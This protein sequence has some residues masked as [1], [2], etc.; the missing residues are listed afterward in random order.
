MN[1]RTNLTL[2]ETRVANG[3]EWSNGKPGILFAFIKQ[4]RGRYASARQQ[5][6]VAPGD[7][8]VANAS[9]AGR[10]SAISRE[11]MTMRYF[12]ASLGPLVGLFAS[13]EV[14]QLEHLN[15]RLSSLL[16]H[17]GTTPLAREC[18]ALIDTVPVRVSLA[19]RGHLLKVVTLLFSSFFEADASENR[20]GDA[21]H[22]R[23]LDLLERMD[24]ADLQNLSVSDLA[25]RL[26]CGRR[27]LNRLFHDHFGTSVAALK[28]EMRLLKAAALLRDPA[29]KVINVAM[30]SGFNHLGL[31]S[32]CFKR[33]FGASPSEWRRQNLVGHS[34]PHD[35]DD[36][37]AAPKGL[38]YEDCHF[39]YRGLCPWEKG[40]PKMVRPASGAQDGTW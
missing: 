37:S 4:G 11:G 39:R 30:D 5:Q 25:C 13:L 40:H 9:G 19:H 21:N 33:R 26:G 24:S 36:D 12:Y 27:H 20:S 8:L 7:V 35:G 15:G 22:V 32:T 14:C 38:R 17:P 28:M 31:F 6:M 16:Y 2:Q 23:M 34:S 1:D 18:H 3:A 10:L 29:A